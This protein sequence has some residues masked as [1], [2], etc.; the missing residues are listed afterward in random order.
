MKWDERPAT[1]TA[2]AGKLDLESEGDAGRRDETNS[3][4]LMRIPGHRFNLHNLLTFIAYN[5]CVHFR[6]AASQYA[7]RFKWNPVP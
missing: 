4:F 2:S 7:R 1:W 5:H 3:Q 6:C